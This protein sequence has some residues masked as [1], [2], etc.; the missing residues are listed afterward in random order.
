MSRLKPGRGMEDDRLGRAVRTRSA[1]TKCEGGRARRAP[2]S[3]AHPGMAG[4]DPI[5]FV[6][7][8]TYRASSIEIAWRDQG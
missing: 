1:D 3:W 4:T 8:E 5:G 2:A 6:P 7:D